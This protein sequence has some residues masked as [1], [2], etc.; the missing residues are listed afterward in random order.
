MGVHQ[1]TNKKGLA[2][3]RCFE[4]NGRFRKFASCSLAQVPYLSRGST[5]SGLDSAQPKTS[6]RGLRSEARE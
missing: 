4:T 1:Q 5:A 6:N 2:T 3:R